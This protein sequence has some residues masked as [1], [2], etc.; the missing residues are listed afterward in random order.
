M[1]D[2]AVLC[3]AMVATITLLSN[4]PAAA[5]EA[6]ESASSPEIDMLASRVVRLESDAG[7]CSG[8]FVDPR[9]YI[10]TGGHCV[11]LVSPSYSNSRI[12]FGQI[13]ESVDVWTSIH[14]DQPATKTYV[15]TVVRYDRELDLALLRLVRRYDDTPLTEVPSFAISKA[16][17]KLMAH[18]RLLGYPEGDLMMAIE[19]GE[20]SGV[21]RAADQHISFVRSSVH[22]NPGF[23][24]GPLLDDRDQV[25][26]IHVE[27]AGTHQNTAV[28][29]ATGR[30]PREWIEAMTSGPVAPAAAELPHVDAKTDLM[31]A[32]GGLTLHMDQY[33]EDFFVRV[34]GD[35]TGKVTATCSDQTDPDLVLWNTSG[36]KLNAARG[37]LLLGGSGERFLQLALFSPNNK[38]ATA[39]TCTIH[40][41][42][43][44]IVDDNEHLASTRP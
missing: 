37:E 13:V 6:M 28:A 4:S 12:A 29:R 24:G 30:V 38:A 31:I 17:P 32:A 42:N 7:P 11:S 23:S 2:N 22:S 19:S 27:V 1:S 36:A 9:G 35:V 3:L 33:I 21:N 26:G 41:E 18:V 5:D 25:I 20:L 15:A 34:P 44:P 14:P 8:A 40:V 43:I 16:T 39:R 10:L